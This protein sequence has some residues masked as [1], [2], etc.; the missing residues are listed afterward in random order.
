MIGITCWAVRS[1]L[2][3][4]GVRLVHQERNHRDY[5]LSGAAHPSYKNGKMTTKMG[6]VV[7]GPKN[8][9]KLEHRVVM[10]T[11]LGRTLGRKEQ[12]HHLNGI[13]DDNRPENLALTDARRHE[14]FTIVKILQKRIRGLEDEIERLTIHG[15]GHPKKC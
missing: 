7:V 5:C 15:E 3:K 9:R 8:N 2:L 1:R 13:R 6:Y 12:V 14:R 10:E 11:S 4:A